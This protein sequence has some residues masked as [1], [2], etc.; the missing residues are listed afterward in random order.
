M[1]LVDAS[2][3]VKI[4]TIILTVLLHIGC[5][6]WITRFKLHPRQ[7]FVVGYMIDLTRINTKF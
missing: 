1:Y 3:W 7:S 6:K 2:M 4:A 5:S